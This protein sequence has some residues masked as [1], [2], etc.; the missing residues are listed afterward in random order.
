MLCGR[1]RGSF[2][3]GTQGTVWQEQRVFCGRYRE[4]FHSC[5]AGTQGILVTGTEGLEREVQVCFRY[6]RYSSGRY[7][8][9]MVGTQ[10]IVWQ[11]QRVVLLVYS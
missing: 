6:T 3:A 2:A 9:C 7:R 5:A 10:G 8:G 11:V 4:S 1:Y